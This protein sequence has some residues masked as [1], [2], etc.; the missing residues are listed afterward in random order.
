MVAGVFC[1]DQWVGV[2]GV[3]RSWA[4]DLN[5]WL[6]LSLL[7]QQGHRFVGTPSVVTG[8]RALR[9]LIVRVIPPIL[10]GDPTMTFAL[11]PEGLP[12]PLCQRIMA[13]AA[14]VRV[15]ATPTTEERMVR[16]GVL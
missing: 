10:H 15:R 12:M 7:R 9:R 16:M 4:G 6:C 1:G 11:S 2:G 5:L 13:M 8:D 3:L 14:P